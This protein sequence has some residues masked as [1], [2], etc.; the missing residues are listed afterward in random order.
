MHG[1][2]A[3]DFTLLCCAGSV[4]IAVQEAAVPAFL[5]TE[6]ERFAVKRGARLT[7]SFRAGHK[8]EWLADTGIAVLA[9][10]AGLE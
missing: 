2:V 1:S 6:G 8:N 5:L 3:F 7:V 9:F 4:E 10:L